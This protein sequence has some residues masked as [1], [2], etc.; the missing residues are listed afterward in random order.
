MR[1]LVLGSTGFL[2]GHITERL[3]ALPG[4]Q[5][6]TGGRAPDS[7]VRCDLATDRPDAL[8]EVLAGIAPDAV[9]NCAGVVGG[10][11]LTLAEV[12]A[13]GPAALCAAVRAA[14]PGARL[15]HLGSAAEYG[16]CPGGERTPEE[17]PARPP[18]PYGATKLAGTLAV[19]ASGLDA[20]VL[21]VTNPVGAGAATAGLPGRLAA[22]LRHATA[23]TPHGT[24][25]VGDLSVHRDFVD[26][27][28]VARAVALAATAPGPLPPVLNVGSGRAIPVRDLAHGL[29]RTAGFRGRLEE[30]LNGSGRSAAVPWQ[31][32]DITAAAREL[33]WHPEYTL[34]ESL[35]AL[36]G[37]A[38][39]APAPSPA[40]QDA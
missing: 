20:V 24:V 1:I 30:S 6:L 39:G 9:V 21:R 11:A 37:A 32:A 33:R 29:V 36:W 12:N 17:A 13:R 23:Q 22:E 5:V 40:R 19:T 18:A 27:R 7:D 38:P 16:P 28:D 3:R 15:V 14:A 35:T 4:A 34:A 2:G 10:S 31:C 25:R 26:V 8:A